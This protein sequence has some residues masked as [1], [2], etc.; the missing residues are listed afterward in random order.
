MVRWWARLPLEEVHL[1]VIKEDGLPIIDKEKR[2]H[3]QHTAD[4]DAARGGRPL[5]EAG[6]AQVELLVRERRCG[7]HAGNT[8]LYHLAEADANH[9]GDQI[10]DPRRRHRGQA[11]LDA[12]A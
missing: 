7:Q 4:G 10:A 8:G 9:I 11:K 12:C 5:D 3:A 1:I 6:R 2:E